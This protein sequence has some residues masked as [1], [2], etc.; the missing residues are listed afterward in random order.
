MT[1]DPAIERRVAALEQIVAA[2]FPKTTK[3]SKVAIVEL[4]QGIVGDEFELKRH[5]LLSES[6]S[7]NLVWPRHIGIKLASEFSGLSNVALAPLFNRK[8]HTTIANA[9][10]SIRHEEA[11]SK[12]NAKVIDGLRQRVEKALQAGRNGV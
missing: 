3:D 5:I 2:C 8:N 9:I 12:T 1:T 10:N 11:V 7:A 4:V 6:R